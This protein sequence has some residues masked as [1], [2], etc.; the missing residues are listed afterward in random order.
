MTGE[1]VF[2]L[3]RSG[4]SIRKIALKIGCTHQNIS[5]KLRKY[6]PGY[7][8]YRTVKPKIHIVKNCKFCNTAYTSIYKT[9]QYCSR[10][11][12]TKSQRL[13][14]IPIK[15][16]PPDKARKYHN[17][18]MKKYYQGAGGEIIRNINRQQYRKFKDKSRARS[19]LNQKVA[20]GVIKKPK[21]CSI[22][23]K[24]K[25]RI[26]GHHEDYTKPLDVI[27]VCDVCHCDIHKKM[28]TE[29]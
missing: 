9:S 5:L 18:R 17:E 19:L 3:Y 25:V 10:L 22:C 1:E 4:L 2:K 21:K 27:W 26:V 23:N 24:G 14:D 15:Y 6:Y 7:T 29:K 8:E 12:A 11:C 20:S 13:F 16:L 28:L